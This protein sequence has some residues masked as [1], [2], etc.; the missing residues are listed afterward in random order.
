MPKRIL[1]HLRTP[2]F[3]MIMRLIILGYVVNIV[4]I[5]LVLYKG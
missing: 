2:E 3:R 4:C 5:G 1:N